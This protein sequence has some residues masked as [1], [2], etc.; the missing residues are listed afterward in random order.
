M[1]DRPLFTLGV[2][3]TPSA[4]AVQEAAISILQGMVS[5]GFNTNEVFSVL[6]NSVWILGNAA[7][8][9]GISQEESNRL[10]SAINGV[11]DLLQAEWAKR[12]GHVQ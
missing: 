10:C 4:K 5:G 8:E 12:A 3:T 9:S 11:A 6:L 1:A 7:L 2:P